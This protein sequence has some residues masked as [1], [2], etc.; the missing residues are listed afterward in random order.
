[1]SP[2]PLLSIQVV[3]GVISTASPVAAQIVPDATLPQNA[4]VT[5][6]GSTF[7]ID[8]GTSAGTNLFHSFSEFSVPT[9]TEAFFNNGATI[10][11]IITRVTGSNI[12][13]IDGLIRANGSANL[14]FLN[15]NGIVFGSNSSLDIG[16]SFMSSTAESLHFADGVIFSAIAPTPDPILTISMPVGLQFGRTPSA[17]VNRSQATTLTPFPGDLP[18][19]IDTGLEVASGQTLALVGG[20]IVLENGNLTALQGEIHLMSIGHSELVTFSWSPVRLVFNTDD[21]ETFG[22]ID[23][24]GTS[25]LTASGLGGGAIRLHGSEIDIREDANLLADTFGDANGRGIEIGGD[26]LRLQEDALVS[27][28]TFGAGNGGNLTIETVESVELSG[29]GFA[30][31]QELVLPALVSTLDA[32][33]IGFGAIVATQ[34]EGRA[35]MVTIETRNFIMRDGAFLSTS[36]NSNGMGGDIKVRAEAIEIDGASL[37]S[38][39]GLGTMGNSGDIVLETQTLSIVN[40]GNI[41]AITL[42]SGSGGNIVVRATD[43]VG[44]NGVAPNGLLASGVAASSIFGSGTAGTIEIEARRIVISEGG[45]I[46]SQSGV[47]FAEIDISQGGP[48]NNTILRASE[49]IEVRGASPDDRLTSFPSNVSTTSFGNAPAGDVIIETGNLVVEDTAFLAVD[50]GGTSF[51]GE[52]GNGTADA[53]T[54]EIVADRVRLNTG[55]RLIAATVSGLGGDIILRTGSLQLREQSSINTNAGSSDGGNITLSTD[56]LVALENSDITANALEGRGGRVSIT[57]QG[58]FGTEFREVLTLESDITATSN[59]GAEF[60]GVVEINTPDV[61]PS[62]GLVNVSTETLDPDDR[63]VRGCAEDFNTF[64]IIGRGGLPENPTAG[65]SNWRGWFDTR[66]WRSLSTPHTPLPMT[67]YPLPREV[68]S[69]TIAPDGKVSLIS[70]VPTHATLPNLTCR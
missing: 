36:T 25:T 54:L 60:S 33:N 57:A 22:N 43:I 56:T 67:D 61:D 10:D 45:A 38:S 7:A 34:G 40:S 8:G 53:G 3:V 27:T 49:S 16:G 59:L 64:A 21:I 17:I 19:P 62:S 24:F 14:F 63:V 28:A 58:V 35:G 26:R 70:Q 15:P 30:T 50:G 23:I 41:F 48:S 5:P 20:D 46:V 31:T 9:G 65:L 37:L 1:M 18:L 2:S 4:I 44:I 47:S 11:N 42:G 68:T 51:L 6:N 29:P 12:S 55:G 66:D 69:W 52:N 32:N 13:S 39:T